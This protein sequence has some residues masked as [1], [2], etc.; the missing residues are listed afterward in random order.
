MPRLSSLSSRSLTGVGLLNPPLVYVSYN[1]STAAFTSGGTYV[2][3]LSMPSGGYLQLRNPNSG[4]GVIFDLAS[5]IAPS[6]PFTLEYWIRGTYTPS[7]IAVSVGD[8]SAG[9]SM[10]LNFFNWNTVT[11]GNIIGTFYYNNSR[12]QS[13]GIAVTTANSLTHVA[14]EVNASRQARLYFNGTYRGQV[15]NGLNNVAYTRLQI[16]QLLYTQAGQQ[17]T[18]TDIGPVHLYRGLGFN[19]NGSY[20]IPNSAYT[21][22]ANTL[23]LGQ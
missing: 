2:S 17:G 21:A 12:G 5:A 16:G 18:F 22:N 6:E 20:T 13:A 15:A 11:S 9:N 10:G 19:T 1:Y 23:F 3:D 8:A 7:N 14:F 4:T